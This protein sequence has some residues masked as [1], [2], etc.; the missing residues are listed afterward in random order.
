MRSASGWSWICSS[1]HWTACLI[2]A[3]PTAMMP[4]RADPPRSLA[5]EAERDRDGGGLLAVLA[6]VPGLPLLVE[7]LD[8]RDVLDGAP[9][10]AGGAPHGVVQRLADLVLGGA[11][12]LRS[13]EASGHSGGAAGG[14]HRGQRHQLHRLRIQRAFAVVEPGELLHFLGHRGLLCVRCRHYTSGRA[15]LPPPPRDWPVLA[16]A[17]WHL[18]TAAMGRKWPGK[19]AACRSRSTATSRCRWRD[20]SRPTW[21]G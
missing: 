16:P 21:N 9:R 8:T 17:N 18:T 15:S 6:L 4:P 12:L 20:R 5:P 1:I 11:G 3:S 13:R 19:E 10:G 2:G 7:V 14:G